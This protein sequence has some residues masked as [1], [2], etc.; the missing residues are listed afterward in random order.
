M[1]DLR[2]RFWRR[3]GRDMKKALNQM[4]IAERP[5]RVYVEGLG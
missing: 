5:H 3:D 4:D 2:A 1:N